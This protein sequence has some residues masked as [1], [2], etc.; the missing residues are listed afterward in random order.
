MALARDQGLERSSLIEKLTGDNYA[1]WSTDMKWLLIMKGVWNAIDD[2]ENVDEADDMKAMALI[3]LNVEK[4]LKTS[5]DASDT[6]RE[7]WDKLENAYK[8][9]SNARK[10]Q[11]KRELTSI[12][13]KPKESITMYIAR[14][15][16]LRDQLLAAGYEASDEEV[17]LSALAGLPDSYASIVDTL[18]A[19]STALDIDDIMPKLLVVEQRVKEHYDRELE[20]VKAYLVT[21]Y[22]CG[23][24]GHIKRNCPDNRKKGSRTHSEWSERTV[25]M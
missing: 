9:K 13:L 7:A 4:H 14:A 19:T 17:A 5:V 25:P 6:A 15:K 12:E 2:H 11:L 20:T 21:C 18:Q 1:T 16:E 22:R 10:L 23:K 24:K 8:A 3:G